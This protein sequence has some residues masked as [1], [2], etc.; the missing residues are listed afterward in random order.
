MDGSQIERDAYIIISRN[1]KNSRR[2]VA[3][4]KV[5]VPAEVEVGRRLGRCLGWL[6][7]MWVSVVGVGGCLRRVRLVGVDGRL[8]VEC[9]V[10]GADQLIGVQLI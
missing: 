7:W 1:G 5:A 10:W 3:V 2:S 9:F 4:G 6:V 8:D